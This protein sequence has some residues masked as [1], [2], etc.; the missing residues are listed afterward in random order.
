[1]ETFHWKWSFPVAI[2]TKSKINVCDTHQR[3][4]HN[5]NVQGF[6]FPLLSCAL[7]FQKRAEDDWQQYHTQDSRWLGQKELEPLLRTI[8]RFMW[9]VKCVCNQPNTA[10]E[11]K[12]ITSCFMNLRMDT[13]KKRNKIFPPRVFLCDLIWIICGCGDLIQSFKEHEFHG[14]KLICKQKENPPNFIT[15][16]FL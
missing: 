7:L 11:K 4:A 16:H 8:Y 9:S 15:I 6:L 13:I 14:F 5:F 1:M 3:P 12:I 10:R 2:K